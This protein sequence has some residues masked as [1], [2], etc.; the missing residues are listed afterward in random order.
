MHAELEAVKKVEEDSFG[1]VKED[2]SLPTDSCSED[3]LEKYLLS[4]M[5]SILDTPSSTSSFSLMKDKAPSRNLPSEP[6]QAVLEPKPFI[7]TLRN[8]VIHIGQPSLTDFH[9]R[10]PNSDV[11][12]NT[13]VTFSIL[14]SAPK[15]HASTSE[16]QY[17]PA[18]SSLSDFNPLPSP[19]VT[20]TIQPREQPRKP[21]PDETLNTA[22]S[23]TSL[24]PVSPGEKIGRLVDSEARP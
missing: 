11:G 22:E 4:Q 14:S 1:V 15:A 10:A 9:P 2:Q 3:Q 13:S 24:T 18:R 17:Q 5:D 16:E 12:A 6:S 19:F 8:E 23:D 21:Y 20:R 7:S